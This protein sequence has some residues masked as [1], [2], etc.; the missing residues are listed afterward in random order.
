MSPRA[1]YRAPE[2]WKYIQRPI[3]RIRPPSYTQSRCWC[4]PAGHAREAKISTT[5]HILILVENLPVPFDRRVWQEAQA[6]RAA[7]HDVSVIC[8]KAKGYTAA[9]EVLEGVH[10]YRHWL[11]EAHSLLGYPVEYG[12]ALTLQ[13]ILSLQVQRRR[14]IDVI[15]ACNPPDLMFLVAL[16]HRLV[17]GTR[18]IFDHHDLSPE[19]YLSKVGHRDLLFSVLSALERQTFR[20]AD[21]S[22]ATN[23]TFRD[24]AVARGRMPPD[25]VFVVKSYPDAARTHRL[26]P[27]PQLAGTGK[28]I[29]GYVGVM[30]SQD[31]VETLIHAMNE[32]VHVH[33][34]TDLYCVLVG[35][36]PEYPRLKALASTLGLEAALHFT[37]YLTGP[38]LLTHLSAFDIGVI[39]DPPNGF[40]D[41]LSMNKVFEYMM[42]GI[43][44]VQFD[45]RQARREA[46]DASLVVARHSPEAMADAIMA[47]A[48]DP[49]RRR[50][51]GRAG[52]RIAER[53]FQW[54]G[55]AAR[56]L[57]AYDA[58]FANE[59]VRP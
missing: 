11:P 21:A 12:V 52:R 8:P 33:A 38:A 54:S 10:I 56:Y 42:L 26:A 1:V 29:V 6:L 47:L 50:R 46:A 59:A 49:R 19:L 9:H 23:E 37:G 53:D 18:F 57:A 45:L 34:R 22:I 55:Q 7:G 32:I 16:L 39:P 5:R 30:G 36:G 24:I 15:Q 14:R 48:N 4:D 25:R 51:M 41:K 44:F 3:E 17:F 58:I 31:G 20:F 40:N 28:T 35:D 13:L 27:S 2:Q 43:P